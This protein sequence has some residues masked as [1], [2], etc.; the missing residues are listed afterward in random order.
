MLP[1][2]AAVPLRPATRIEIVEKPDVPTRQLM[3]DADN[4]SRE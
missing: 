1:H 3:L 4:I 2:G